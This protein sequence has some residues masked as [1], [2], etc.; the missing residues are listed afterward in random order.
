MESLWDFI[1]TL[2]YDNKR[3][4]A[5]RLIENTSNPSAKD[6]YCL[7]DSMCPFSREELNARFDR[8]EK[9]MSEGKFCSSEEAHGILDSFVAELEVKHN[10]EVYA[11]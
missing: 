4:L 5:E 7:E 1:K 11:Y 10:S 8:I 6:D 2:S 9:D 3:W